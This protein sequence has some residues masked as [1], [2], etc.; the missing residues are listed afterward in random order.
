MP[1]T[2]FAEIIRVVCDGGGD[3]NEGSRVVEEIGGG[4][5]WRITLTVWCI[6]CGGVN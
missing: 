5:G 6:A 3:D 4:R 1:R 2:R